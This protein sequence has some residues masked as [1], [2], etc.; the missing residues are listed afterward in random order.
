MTEETIK[1]E[2]VIENSELKPSS[3]EALREYEV[4]IKFLGRGCV[5][6]VGCQ[7]IAFESVETAMAAINTY[8]ANPCDEQKRWRKILR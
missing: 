6:S 5:V 3:K 2:E 7:E 4:R 1:L 8:V